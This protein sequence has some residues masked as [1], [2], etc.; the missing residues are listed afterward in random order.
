MCIRDRAMAGREGEYHLSFEAKDFSMDAISITCSYFDI[1]SFVDVDT[2][3]IKDA[4][5]QM[6]DATGQLYDGTLQ[7]KKGLTAL[8]GGL[9]QLADGA[10]KAKEDVYKRQG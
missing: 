6:S 5:G 2:Q 10:A 7:L 9:D 1:N 3:E 8:S 4:V